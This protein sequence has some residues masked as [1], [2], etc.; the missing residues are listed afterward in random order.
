MISYLK[1]YINFYIPAILI[2]IAGMLFY[3]ETCV[4]SANGL[5]SL[6][7]DFSCTNAADMYYT[8]L[9]DRVLFFKENKKSI[10][11]MCSGRA[12]RPDTIFGSYKE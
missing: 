8:T 7:H 6:I 10:L 9:A 2:R 12:Y 1:F 3:T 5:L 11:I 4:R